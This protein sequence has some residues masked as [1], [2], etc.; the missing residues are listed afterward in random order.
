MSLRNQR[1]HCLSPRSAPRSARSHEGGHVL[2]NGELAFT[3]K[4]AR[5][6]AWDFQ[7]LHVQDSEAVFS[8]TSHMI[9]R[10]QRL[11]G[12]RRAL[13]MTCVAEFS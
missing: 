6:G 2:K 10:Q 3:L 7:H 8:R 4:T 13:Y 5:P 12:R 11:F 9:V 1:W